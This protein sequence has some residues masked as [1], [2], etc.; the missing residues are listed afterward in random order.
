[1]LKRFLYLDSAAVTD[2]L[3]ALEGGIRDSFQ[4]KIATGG[5]KEGGLDAKVLKGTLARSR[6]DEELLIMSD[7]PQARFERLL[8]LAAADPEAA[9]WVEITDPEVELVEAGTGAMIDVECEVY[10]P[11]TIK[12]LSSSGGITEALDVL[13]ALLPAAQTFGFDTTGLPGKKEREGVKKFAAALGGN[14]VA[15]GELDDSEWQLAGQLKAAFINGEIEGRARVVGKVSTRWNKGT[16][17]PLLA[18]PG[19]SLLPRA[20]RRA[21]ERK[22]P[23][24]DEEGN[25]LEGPAVML[26]ILAIYR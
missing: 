7:T 19:T 21:L 8:K 3:S 20:E 2:Y 14:Q 18:L 11:D 23:T 13:E 4:T 5:S 26:D 9:G 22:R 17:K 15:V 16:W 25:Y 12:A 1:M 24:E 10:V 6:A